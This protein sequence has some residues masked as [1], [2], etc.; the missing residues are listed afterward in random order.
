MHVSLLRALY[1]PLTFSSLPKKQ[2]RLPGIY[3][4]GHAD[5]YHYHHPRL[6]CGRSRW[7]SASLLRAGVT[8][9]AEAAA[10]PAPLPPP[11]HPVAPFRRHRVAKLVVVVGESKEPD[12][13]ES[14][15]R[16]RSPS[17][18]ASLLRLPRLAI[19]GVRC[20]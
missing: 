12:Q 4:T 11:I 3:L 10:F 18:L 6:Y 15:S 5:D 9:A 8:M 2:G 17:R 16:A 1:P 19:S 20:C 13:L 14:R 7:S